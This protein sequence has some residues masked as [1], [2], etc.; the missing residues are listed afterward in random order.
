MRDLDPPVKECENH[1]CWH[2]ACY[3]CDIPLRASTHLLADHPGTRPHAGHGLCGRCERDPTVLTE[4]DLKD[5][6]HILLSD[7][8]MIRIMT[9]HPAAFSWHAHRRKR[10]RLG[11]YS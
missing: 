7:Q 10:L 3:H 11:E 6:R 9:H 2:R 4:D 5:Q 8:D 1:G